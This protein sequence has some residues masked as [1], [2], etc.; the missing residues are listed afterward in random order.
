MRRKTLLSMFVV[1]L[2]VGAY[3]A[4]AVSQPKLVGA[5]VDK[6]PKEVYKGLEKSCEPFEGKVIIMDFL[7]GFSK[8]MVISTVQRRLSKSQYLKKRVWNT[9][10]FGGICRSVLVKS[11]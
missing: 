6:S 11:Q 4:Y 8:N 7:V 1:L 3:A 10:F 2:L 9:R 5:T